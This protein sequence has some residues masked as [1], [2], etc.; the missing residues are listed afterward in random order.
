VKLAFAVATLEVIY[1][2]VILLYEGNKHNCEISS[3][4]ETFVGGVLTALGATKVALLDLLDFAL[5]S[6]KHG[7]G[8]LVMK[9]SFMV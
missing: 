4:L 9:N 2:H 5:V 8:P 1:H 7:W 3:V 6:K